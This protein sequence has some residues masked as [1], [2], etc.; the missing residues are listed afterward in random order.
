MAKI[1]NTS[2]RELNKKPIPHEL[3]KRCQKL[4]HRQTS[5]TSGWHES[6]PKRPLS[7]IYPEI[8][9]N[10]TAKYIGSAWFSSLEDDRNDACMPPS[11]SLPCLQ[12]LKRGR[13]PSQFKATFEVMR[14]IRALDLILLPYFSLIMIS[15]IL[16]FL[17]AFTE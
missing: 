14:T 9:I 3:F 11:F 1:K 8:G 2:P 10:S 7:P 17:T 4:C 16:Y 5:R 15:S 13:R 6:A 12:K